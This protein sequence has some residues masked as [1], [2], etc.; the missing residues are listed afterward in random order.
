MRED[1]S[2]NV[3]EELKR[4]TMRQDLDQQQ[5]AT[6]VLNVTRDACT[7]SLVFMEHSAPKGKKYFQNSNGKIK[8]V[9]TIAIDKIA[10]VAEFLNE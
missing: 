2:K 10:V 7:Q 9:K 1:H 6:D 4:L 8:R 3:E 5:D